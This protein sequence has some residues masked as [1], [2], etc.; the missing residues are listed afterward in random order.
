MHH[1]DYNDWEARAHPLPH[2]PGRAEIPQPTKPLTFA[3]GVVT[4]HKP[5]RDPG[6]GLLIVAL[7][8]LLIACG[9]LG[10]YY[11]R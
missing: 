4:R 5:R 9:L 11:G 3:P 10:Y 2:L 8:W 7:P 6:L 1:E